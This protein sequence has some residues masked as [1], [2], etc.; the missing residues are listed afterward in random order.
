MAGQTSPDVPNWI[1]G[2]KALESGVPM[3]F[4]VPQSSLAGGDYLMLLEL[5][6]PPLVLAGLEKA[7]LAEYR[8]LSPIW[9]QA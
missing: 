3:M 2:G 5:L 9:L 6:V 7:R 8:L 1:P 4:N